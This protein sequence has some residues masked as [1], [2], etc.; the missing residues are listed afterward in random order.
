MNENTKETIK[1]FVRIVAIQPESVYME[2]V[3]TQIVLIEFSNGQKAFVYD[4]MLCSRDMIGKTKEIALTMLTHSLEKTE[5]H[6]MKIIPDLAAPFFEIFG[7]IQEIHIPEK[8]RIIGGWRDMIINFG[9]GKIVIDVNIEKY[10][11]LN[12]NVDDYIRANGRVDLI[13]IE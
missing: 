3:Y 1:F 13:S 8:S 5:E 4:N 6:K 12:L 10:A 9:V 11:E 7:R 2:K